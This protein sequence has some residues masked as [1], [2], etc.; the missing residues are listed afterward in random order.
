MS[1][2]GPAGRGH[3]WPTFLLD[4]EGGTSLRA[5]EDATFSPDGKRAFWAQLVSLRKRSPVD[6][7]T[8]ALDRPEP[9]A[10]ETGISASAWNPRPLHDGLGASL[11]QTISVFEPPPASSSARLAGTRPGSTRGLLRGPPR[12]W[13]YSLRRGRGNAPIGFGI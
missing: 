2:T 6:L 8:A 4:T 5:G 9:E 7:V 3:D 10:V 12:I 11:G 13:T 1:I